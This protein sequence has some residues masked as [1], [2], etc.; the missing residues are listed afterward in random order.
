MS[1]DDRIRKELTESDTSNY[2]GVG[3]PKDGVENILFPFIGDLKNN[4]SNGIE[5][6]LVN[7]TNTNGRTFNSM[8]K[9]NKK[10]EYVLQQFNQVVGT[11]GLKSKDWIEFY[12]KEII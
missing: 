6:E 7:D 8:L 2:S 10:N 1:E 11:Y 4:V 5:V 12:P 9:L 3:L